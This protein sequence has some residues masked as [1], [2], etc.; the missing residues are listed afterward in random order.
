MEPMRMCVVCRRMRTKDELIRAV[1][2]D[3]RTEIDDTKKAQG[4]GAYI[5]ADGECLM[6]ARQRRAFERSFSGAVAAEFYDKLEGLA[7]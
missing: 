1:K 3:G 2:T 7:K 4:R 5:C 6:K